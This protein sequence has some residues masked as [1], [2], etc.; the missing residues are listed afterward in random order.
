MDT[1][2]SRLR[3]VSKHN[4]ERYGAAIAAV[5]AILSKQRAAAC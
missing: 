2:L 1:D 4:R 5:V 3:P